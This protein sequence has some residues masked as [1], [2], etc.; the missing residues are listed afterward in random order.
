MMTKPFIAALTALA[1]AAAPCAL[2]AQV[3][4]A[5]E[6]EINAFVIADANQDGYLALSEFK[7]FVRAMAKSGQPT[8]QTIRIFGAYKFAFAIVDANKDSLASPQ[9]LRSADTDFRNQ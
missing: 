5:T 3:F 9:E 6:P 4:S 7:I 8:A 2:Q 1:C